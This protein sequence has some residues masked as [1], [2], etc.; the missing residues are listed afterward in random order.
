ML[1]RIL[2]FEPTLP[3]LLTPLGSADGSGVYPCPAEEFELAV[4]EL[5][6]GRVHDRSTGAGAEV[7]LCTDGRC[8]LSAVD[9]PP[10][11]LSAGQS[12]LVPATVDRYRLEGT[13]TL[14]RAAVPDRRSEAVPAS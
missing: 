8:R 12:V 9:A 6:A 3:Q 7:L 10:L 5:R 11:E 14:F 1:L 2:R 4:V 13:A